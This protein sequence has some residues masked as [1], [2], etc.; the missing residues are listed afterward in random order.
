VIVLWAA[1][2]RPELPALARDLAR[3]TCRAA[4]F[5]AECEPDLPPV[6]SLSRAA[7][8]PARSSAFQIRRTTKTIASPTAIFTPLIEPPDS[9]LCAVDEVVTCRWHVTAREKN[10]DRYFWQLPVI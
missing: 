1:G 7:T 6:L 9:T 4:T 3:W 5:L 10:V 8:R 2:Q